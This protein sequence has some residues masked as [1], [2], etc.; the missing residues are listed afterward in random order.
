MFE[1]LRTHSPAASAL[2]VRSAPGVLD[3]LCASVV[4]GTFG[5][6]TAASELCPERMSFAYGDKVRET[7]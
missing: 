7:L 1:R 3:L 6:V 4:T 2:M 5:A